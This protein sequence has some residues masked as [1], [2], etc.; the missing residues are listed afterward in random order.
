MRVYVSVDMEGTGC[1][2]GEADFAALIPGVERTGDRGVRIVAPDPVTAF[3]A[4]LAGIRLAG[5][6]S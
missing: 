1:H 3:R 6:A 4:F 5:L 2:A